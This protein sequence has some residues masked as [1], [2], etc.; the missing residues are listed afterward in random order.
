LNLRLGTDN[1]RCPYGYL[2]I[3]KLI[4]GDAETGSRGVEMD[5]GRCRY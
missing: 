2:E 1:G 4:I 3:Q 5:N